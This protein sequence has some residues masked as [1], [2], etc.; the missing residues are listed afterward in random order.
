LVE[1]GMKHDIVTVRPYQAIL[2]GA[3]SETRRPATAIEERRIERGLTPLVSCR[4]C[5]STKETVALDVA[6]AE[7]QGAPTFADS[8]C[9]ETTIEEPKPEVWTFSYGST[10]ISKKTACRRC[11]HLETFANAPTTCASCGAKGKGQ[12]T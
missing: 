3:P 2:F 10:V 1:E 5:G 8:F 4:E 6:Y 11:G 12:R 7:R 9:C